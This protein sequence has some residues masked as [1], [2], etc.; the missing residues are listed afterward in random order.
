MSPEA[1]YTIGKILRNPTICKKISVVAFDEAVRLYLGS[2][3]SRTA[4]FRLAYY[5]AMELFS[6]S[7]ETY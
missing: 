3:F 7:N 5:Q 2:N 4:D 6:P 1:Y